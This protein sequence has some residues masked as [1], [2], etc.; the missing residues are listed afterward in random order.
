MST[1][2][3]T[4]PH[5][6]C[7]RSAA[8]TLTAVLAMGACSPEDPTGPAQ[9]EIQSSRVAGGPDVVAAVR[10]GAH[11]DLLN[12]PSFVG[13][14]K[15]IYN[16]A[17]HAERSSDGSANGSITMVSHIPPGSNEDGVALDWWFEIE[18]DCLEVEGDMAW[19]TG[20]VVRARTDSPVGPGTGGS[21]AGGLGLVMVRDMGPGNG[22]WINVG[23][24]S[25]YGAEDCRDKPPIGDAETSGNVTIF[26]RP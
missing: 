12:P 1:R 7:F 5:R 17:I 10:G 23:P 22:D 24:P 11:F 2:H 6:S 19:M 13:D 14:F 16:F 26:P 25:F 20:P 3:C 8:L 4:E 15:W 18:V 21:G 9:D